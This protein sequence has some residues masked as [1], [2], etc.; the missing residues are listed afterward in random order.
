MAANAAVSMVSRDKKPQQGGLLSLFS[1][2]FRRSD[3]PEI[4]YHHENAVAVPQ[5]SLPM[6]PLQDLDPMFAELVVRKPSVGLQTSNFCPVPTC[7]FL[8][9][10]AGPHRGAQSRHVRSASREEVA[11]L[12]HQENGKKLFADISLA[13]YQ[14][15]VIPVSL[16][17]RKQRRK[18]ERAAG[19]SFT[20]TSSGLCLL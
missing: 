17:F 15:L 12:P 1:C 2:C 9:G 19:L 5:P 4:T 20:S 13:W 18:K 7:V 6:P 11:A 16:C 14:E 3:P 8:L 10:R